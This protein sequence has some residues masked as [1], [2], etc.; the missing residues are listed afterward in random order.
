MRIAY[1]VPSLAYKG[2]VIVV[3]ELVEQMC[4]NGHDCTVLYFDD[5]VQ[6]DFVCPTKLISQYRKIDFLKFDIVHTHGIR[7]DIFV[8]RFREYSGQVVYISTIHNYVLQDFSH[9]YNWFIAQIFGRLWMNCL[10]KHDRI[11][12]LSMNAVEYYRRWFSDDKLTYVYNTRSLNEAEVLSKAEKQ[13]LMKFKGGDRLIGVNALLSPVKGI[14]ILIKA[15]PKL[16]KYR[17]FIVGDGKSRAS[18]ERLAYKLNVDHRC[19][20][21]G[22]RK[23]AYRYLPYYDIFAMPSRS[24]GF[25]LALLEAAFFGKQSVV[26]DIPIIKEAFTS[27]EVSMFQLTKPD[28]IIEAVFSADNN[29]EMGECMHQKFLECYSPENMYKRYI[30]IYKYGLNNCK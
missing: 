14:D 30:F 11:V 9:Q 8:Y 27:K 28:S 26:S 24:E 7:P 13:E 10:K 2:P 18:L 25:P 29:C 17:L 12:A 23:D 4:V 5:I 21:A 20:F 3:K 16:S 1:I 6:V 15:L 22:V 19:F